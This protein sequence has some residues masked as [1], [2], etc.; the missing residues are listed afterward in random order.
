ML[1]KD[2]KYTYIVAGLLILAT[3]AHAAGYLTDEQYKQIVA[4]LVG[5]GAISIRYAISKI[6]KN[7]IEAVNAANAALKVPPQ[8][9]F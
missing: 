8:A 6:P 1:N 5:G 2:N 9:K 4:Y 3:I 7:I